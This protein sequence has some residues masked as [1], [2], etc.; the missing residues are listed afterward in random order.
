MARIFL[1]RL[2]RWASGLG[3]ILFV[4][5]GMMFYGAGDPI[6]R[7][8][9]DSAEFRSVDPKVLEALRA[10]YGLDKPFLEQFGN[11]VTNL[12]R[13]DWG[14]S[15]RLNVDRPVWGLVQFRLPISMQLGFAAILILEDRV[16][17]LLPVAGGAAIVHHQRGDTMRRVCL[18]LLVE[19]RALC[20]MRTAVNHHHH[21]MTRRCRSAVLSRWR[22]S[23][24]AERKTDS[25]SAKS[26]VDN[27]RTA[28]LCGNAVR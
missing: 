20:A 6:K 17:E 15:I 26:A 12:L 24:L 18:R 11:Y 3:V 22:A 19:R 9:A 4:T 28:Q 7:M 16:G 8:F 27:R 2:I 10:K 21:R 14:K 13:G 25:A 23:G 5:Y 1:I